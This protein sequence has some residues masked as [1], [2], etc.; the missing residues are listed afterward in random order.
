MYL[1]G[2]PR[3]NLVHDMVLRL[4]KSLFGQEE[5]PI[6]WFENLEKGLEDRGFNPSIADPCMF[7]S[8]K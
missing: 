1:R 7:M 6:L 4:K 3:E 8:E 2:P 5:A